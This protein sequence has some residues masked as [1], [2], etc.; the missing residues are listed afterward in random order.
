MK[1]MTD[2]ERKIALARLALIRAANLLLNVTDIL[3]IKDAQ[4]EMLGAE[5]RLDKI[6]RDYYD[7]HEGHAGEDQEVTR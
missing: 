3:A 2:Y 6:A 4:N 5:I 7:S 1:S